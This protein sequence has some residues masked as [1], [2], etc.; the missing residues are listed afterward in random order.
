MNVLKSLLSEENLQG[1]AGE[2][3]RLARLHCSKGQGSLRAGN[4]VRRGALGQ[5]WDPN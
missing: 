2:T 3:M 4:G 5:L 1:T